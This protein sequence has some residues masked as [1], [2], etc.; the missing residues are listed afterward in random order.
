MSAAPRSLGL[1]FAVA[2]S[3]A[4]VVVGCGQ[5]PLDVARNVD[6]GKFQGKWYEIARLP[7]ATQTDCYGTTAFY[8]QSGGSGDLQLV[9]Q[10]NV[11]KNDGPLSTVTMSATVPDSKVP[12]KLALNVGGYSGDYWILDVG[13]HYEY[14]IVGHPSRLY[15]WILSRTPTLDLDT[16]S[17]LVAKAQS[18]NFDTKQL[19]FTPQPPAGERVSAPGPV[20]SVPPAMSTGCSAA[21]VRPRHSFSRWGA[22]LVSLLLLASGM[23]RRV[24]TKQERSGLRS[25]PDEDARKT[26]GPGGSHGARAVVVESLQSQDTHLAI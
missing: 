21:I 18:N 22:L 13:P 3:A 12:A 25:R 7:R 23:L 14:A 26:G 4:A 9:N 20:G 24:G 5:E 6:L 8:S 10:C 1:A 11:G 16:T 19:L 2:L 17:A 15:L